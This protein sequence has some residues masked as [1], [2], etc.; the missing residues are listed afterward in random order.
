MLDQLLLFI[1]N[2]V[3][4]NM[5]HPVAATSWRRPLMTAFIMS[6]RAFVKRIAFCQPG[7]KLSSSGDRKGLAGDK[8]GI[9]REGERVGAREREKR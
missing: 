2:D 7:G 3:A 8:R 1:W 9:G 4:R 5:G 6:A